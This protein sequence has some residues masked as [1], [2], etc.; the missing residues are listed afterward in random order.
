L[1]RL[2]SSATGLS[3]KPWN[4]RQY[5][6][7]RSCCT[8][9]GCPWLHRTPI[10]DM[11]RDSTED[12]PTESSK[13]DT[14]NAYTPSEQRRRCPEVRISSRH[15][16][17]LALLKHTA[18]QNFKYYTPSLRR[19]LCLYLPYTSRTGVLPVSCAWGNAGVWIDSHMQGSLYLF[20]VGVGVVLLYM[21]LMKRDHCA[22][23]V[24]EESDVLQ[25]GKRKYNTIQYHHHTMSAFT[26]YAHLSLCFNNLIHKCLKL[27]CLPSQNSTQHM[28]THH[29]T[30]KPPQS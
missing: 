19:F 10:R 30:V 21:A 9:R 24:R 8:A 26:S 27:Q 25:E 18:I 16:S 28:V 15:G 7:W 12:H 20:S 13:S 6:R 4:C 3:T 29:Q 1:R 5:T 2:A 14:P 11:K 22:L 23:E 17:L